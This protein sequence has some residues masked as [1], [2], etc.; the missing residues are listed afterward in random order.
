MTVLLL[1]PNQQDDVSGSNDSV[2]SSKWVCTEAPFYCT[3]VKPSAASR[4]RAP[5]GVGQW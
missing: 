1:F 5:S 3:W 2:V 4:T